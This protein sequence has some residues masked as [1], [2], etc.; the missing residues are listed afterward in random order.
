MA[1]S[2]Q[3]HRLLQG[4]MDWNTWKEK[5]RTET[6]DLSGS[7]LRSANLRRADLRGANLRGA[8][9]RDADLR[10]ANLSHANLQ[11][12]NLSHAN[13]QGANLKSADLSKAD[14]SKADLSKAGLSKADLS[15][16]DI[17]GAN[18][19]DAHL[20][21]T[22]LKNA[23]LRSAILIHA[24]LSHAQILE[25]DLRRVN[26][27]IAILSYTNLSYANLKGANLNCAILKGASL[28]HTNLSYTNL[29]GTHLSHAHM[30][31]AY[32]N[33]AYLNGAY[34]KGTDLRGADLRGADLRGVILNN[35]YIGG[36]SFGDRDLRVIKGLEAVRHG[37]PSPL[38]INT[39]YLSQGDIPELFVRG[40][41]APDSFLE[42]MK[43]LASK[44]IEYY[45]CFISY[46]HHDEAFA[47]RLYSDLQNKGVRC[48]FAP[49]DM[50]VGDKIRHRIDETIRIYDKLL[51]VLSE[52][53][54]ASTWVAYE[55]ERALNK[56]PNGVPNVLYPVRLDDAI[57]AYT[58]SWA[59]DIKDTR[60]I[61]D[62]T[63]WKNHDIYQK[64]FDRLL[65][66]LTHKQG[67][68]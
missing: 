61:G 65:R 17:G 68:K 12:A 58:T 62:F 67:N 10:G 64:N 22:N 28:N 45:T 47:N 18:L 24:T 56:E 11:G 21:A 3:V 20:I 14:L 49:E 57:L 6:I 30:N 55:V 13:L 25:A 43:A 53:S 5:H 23:N 48:W 33:G 60:H 41:G 36:T 35:A 66:A 51:L 59:Q 19:N 40:T 32:L 4:V 42:Y 2:E 1:H 9:L 26:L 7:S 16:A 39:I 29:R 46:S 27:S 34:L 31:S 8:D 37:G 15:K 54:I 52:H 63:D 50:D 38:S 44:P